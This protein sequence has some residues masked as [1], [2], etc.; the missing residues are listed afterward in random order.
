MTEE[1]N[2][3]NKLL[4]TLPPEV[5]D[6]IFEFSDL[7]GAIKSYFKNNIASK[8]DKS[9]IKIKNGC[10]LCY[11]RYF[12][13]NKFKEC[14]YHKYH[15]NVDV[16]DEKY[17]SLYTIPNSTVGSGRLGRIYMA[18]NNNEYFR[19]IIQNLNNNKTHILSDITN[20]MRTDLNFIN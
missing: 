7:K 10:Q 13:K 9:F 2:T 15:V 12:Y 18:I 19:N 3:D 6:H 20:E 14:Y 11:L 4:Y 1:K 8:I 16:N 17:F 5:L